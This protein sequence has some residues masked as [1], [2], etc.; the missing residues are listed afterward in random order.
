MSHIT[1]IS[2]STEHQV[3]ALLAELFACDVD[4][5][6]LDEDPAAFFEIDSLSRLH[7]LAMVGVRFD[8][9][10]ADD[11]LSELVTLGNIVRRIDA[12]HVERCQ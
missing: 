9:R 6:I 8:V 2:S 5:L 10:F 7:M 3:R 11:E 1:R 4:R 12:E